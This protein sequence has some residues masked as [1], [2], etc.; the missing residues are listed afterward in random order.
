MNQLK[1]KIIK[2]IQI[3][4]KVGGGSQM[5]GGPMN[6]VRSGPGNI[7]SGANSMS[8]FSQGSTGLPGPLAYLEKTASNIGKR[9]TR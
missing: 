2:Q 5:Y 9:K 1:T 3:L 8:N 7:S 6:V 4:Q